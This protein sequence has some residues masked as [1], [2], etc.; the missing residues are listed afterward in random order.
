VQRVINEALDVKPA[1]DN[2]SADGVVNVV[3]VQVSAALGLSLILG[4]GG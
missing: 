4:C 3:D 1:T 2:L